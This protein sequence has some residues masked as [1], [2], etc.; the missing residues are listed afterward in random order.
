M[1]S[2]LGGLIQRFNTIVNGRAGSRSLMLMHESGLTF[3]QIIVL[4][5]LAFKGDQSISSIA[6]VTRLSAPATSQMIDRLVEAGYV[7]R[8]ES[9]DDR[10]VR[11]VAI[12]PKG[13]RVVEQLHAVR[14]G[15]I[16][17]ALGRLPDAVRSRLASVMA[18][19][20]EAL[21]RSFDKGT[22]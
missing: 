16:E 10:R 14:H 11:V 13:R 17:V 5:A 9:S 2:D 8:E 19:V 7:S 15:E 18:D 3:P 20:V 12:R 22:R 21:E 6:E 4:Y 1:K